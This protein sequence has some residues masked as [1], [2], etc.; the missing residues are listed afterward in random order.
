MNMSQ[1]IVTRILFKGE[2]ESHSMEYFDDKHTA[3]QRYFSIIGADINNKE[4][5][6]NAA[7]I[8]DRDGN[9]LRHEIND[10]RETKD[11]FFILLRY[12][13]KG[14]KYNNS[15]QYYHVMQEDPY[16]SYKAALQ[17]WFNVIA[18]DLKDDEVTAN[19]A[20]IIDS[21]SSEITDGRTFY[22]DREEEP[23]VEQE[24]TDGGEG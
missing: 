12:F 20:F 24:E 3:E 8:I 19:G 14:D 15:V 18:A 2:S 11:K 10:I 1:Y 7:F 9:M 4:T 13:I 23:E 21:H 22:E 16:A 6:Y 17:R 5:T